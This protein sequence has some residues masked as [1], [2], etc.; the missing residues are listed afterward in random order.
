MS[1]S[2]L[3]EDTIICDEMM[4]HTPLFTHRSPHNVAILND[5]DQ[6]IIQ[7]VIKHPNVLCIW[8]IM[9]Q[10]RE[11]ENKDSRIKYIDREQ[12]F[13]LIE[14][15]TLDVLIIGGKHSM[16]HDYFSRLNSNGIVI[17]LCESPFKLSEL[18]TT[19]QQLKALGFQDIL[20]LQFPEPSFVSGWRAAFMAI[21]QGTI[22]RPREKDIFN[23]SF[24]TQYYNLDVHKAAF[25]LPEFMRV[26]LS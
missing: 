20:P 16:C 18:K 9:A 23:K 7:E 6:R 11:H 19:Q 26:E 21:K 2:L 4:A 24:T 8:Q 1:K 17:Q 3:E 10:S 15:N 12:D 22:K 13:S 14:P 5:R 25:A